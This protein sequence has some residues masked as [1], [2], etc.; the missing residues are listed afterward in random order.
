MQTLEIINNYISHLKDTL[1]TF[2]RNEIVALHTILEETRQKGKKTII[3]GNGG[4]GSTASH[5][6]C[7]INKGVSLKQQ[8]KHKIIALTDNI[9]TMLAYANDMGYEEVFVEQMKNFLEEGDIVIGISGSGNSKNVLKAIEYAN[10]KGNTTI[11]ITGYNGGKLK[12]IS[13]MSVNAHV[14]DM[15]IS[16]DLHMILVHLMMKTLCEMGE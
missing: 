12:Q 9:P 16:E 6:A 10:S 11:G 13:K 7:D 3:F 1:D 14:N 5:F 4:S 8:K 15:Q 2:N